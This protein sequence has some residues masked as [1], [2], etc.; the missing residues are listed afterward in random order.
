MTQ[1]LFYFF[2]LRIAH[3]VFRCC[4]KLLFLYVRFS[5]LVWGNAPVCY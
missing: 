3:I 4:P 1:R 2:A 5:C